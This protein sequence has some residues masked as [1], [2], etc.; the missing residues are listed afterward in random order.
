VHSDPATPLIGRRGHVT[1][2]ARAVIGLCAAADGK[3][4]ERDVIVAK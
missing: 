1:Q 4:M 3:K 2:D